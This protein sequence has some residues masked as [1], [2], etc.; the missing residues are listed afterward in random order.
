[1]FGISKKS[2]YGLELMAALARN[3]GKKPLS[4]RRIARKHKLPFKYLEQVAFALK[5]AG[6][7]KSKEGRAGGYSLKEAPEKITIAEVVEVLE[8]PIEVGAC[9]GCPKAFMCSQKNIWSEVG[10]KVRKTI[11]G[12]TIADLVRNY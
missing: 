9:F 5:E 12:R 3:Y 4:L 10:N 6:L 11:E 2:D 7:I 8:G 1:M